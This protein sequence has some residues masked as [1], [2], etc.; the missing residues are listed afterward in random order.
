[1]SAG[2]GALLGLGWIARQTEVKTFPRAICFSS[3]IGAIGMLTFAQ[4]ASLLPAAIAITMVGIGIVVSATAI[5]IYLQII[6][7]PAKRGRILGLY[8][9]AFFGIAPLGNFFAG[10]VMESIGVTA[11]MRT[12]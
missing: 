11:T 12:L 4:S 6:V 9:T 1:S 5:N 3:A 7:H 10:V 8:T 2:I